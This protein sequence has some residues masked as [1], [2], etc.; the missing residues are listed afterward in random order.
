MW[1]ITRSVAGC[2]LV[3]L[4]FSGCY[5]DV[6]PPQPSQPKAQAP[7]EP[8]PAAGYTGQGGG[9]ALGGAKRAAENITDQAQ[10]ESER[11]AEQA[12]PNAET[13]DD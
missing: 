5:E 11:V 4:V 1:S 6:G 3:A 13:D 2:L 8:Q 7:T 9:S 12:D 10:K